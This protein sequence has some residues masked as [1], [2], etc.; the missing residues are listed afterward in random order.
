MRRTVGRSALYGVLFGLATAAVA[1]AVR[2]R[3]GTTL[4][5][6]WDEVRRAARAR[7]DRPHLA[8]G[9]LA[10]AAMDYRSLADKLEQPLLNFVGPLPTG[11]SLPRFDA[12]GRE[13][14]PALNLG[15]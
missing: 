1:E 11:A 10:G 7:L 3:G 6:D 4:L 2:P 5:A 12:P 13:G 15:T 9:Q 14:S 8:P